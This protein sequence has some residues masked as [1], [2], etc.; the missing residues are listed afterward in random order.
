[1]FS[2]FISKPCCGPSLVQI[3]KR[4]LFQRLT[5]FT[6]LYRSQKT[7][8]NPIDFNNFELISYLHIFLRSDFPKI[9]KID[10]SHVCG[11]NADGHLFCFTSAAKMLTFSL[12]RR[13]PMCE[14]LFVAM[15]CRTP[16]A[17][18]ILMKSC[19]GPHAVN[20]FVFHVFLLFAKCVC[21][22][23]GV[24]NSMFTQKHRNC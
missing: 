21:G 3:F 4:I 17:L 15:Y 16:A 20:I 9:F 23:H 14:C 2:L 5:F 10:L 6:F 8:E 19:C 18:R 22:P 24:K 13:F 11:E 1:M 7:H 12:V